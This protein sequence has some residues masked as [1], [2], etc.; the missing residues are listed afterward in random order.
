MKILK[1]V[2]AAVL[3]AVMLAA[4][5]GCSQEAG[6]TESTAAT[7]GNQNGETAVYTVHVETAGG[8][9]ME[10]LD[11]YVYTDSTLQDL[12]NV[13]RTGADG[14]VNLELPVS[15]TYAVTVAAPKGYQMEQSYSFSGNT[16]K[17]CL[18]SA[19]I[20][21]DSLS[22]AVLGVGDVMYDFTVT[23]PSGT[24]VRLSDVLAEKKM[25]ALNFWYTG[26][27][28][29]VTE[30]PFMEQ[31]YQTYKEDVEVIAVDP[32]GESNE[33]IA[34]FQAQQGLTFPMAECPSAW[35]ATF[36][37]TGYPTTVFIDRYGVICAIERGAIT[38]LRP[39]TCVFEHFTAEDYAQKLCANGIS[40][41]I[42]TVKPTEQMPSSDEINAVINSGNVQVTFRAEEDPDSAENTWP[43]VITEKNGEGCIKA[44]NQT[45]EDSYAIIYMDVTLQA[46]QALG[47]DYLASTERGSDIMY[48]IVDDEDIYAISGME[49]EEQW[50]TCYPWVAQEDGTFEVALCYLK[51]SD[52][53]VGDDTV[54]VKNLRVVDSSEIDTP[55]YIPFHAATS[56]DGFEY[57]YPEVFLGEDNYYHVGS[58]NGPLLL[59]EMTNYSQFSEE[60][61][62]WNLVYDDELKIN[63]EVMYDKMLQ[64]F[65]Y[66]SNSSL[67]GVCT[68]NAELG[69]L[70]QEVAKEVGFNTEDENEWLKFCKYYQAYGTDGTQLQD[71]IA[72][73][74][75]F[76]A[77]T[78]T[79]GSNVESNYFY[80][81]RPI[82]PRGLL[83]EF[84]PNR[85]GVYRITSRCDSEHGVEGWIFGAGHEELY[86]YEAAERVD[87]DGVNVNMLYYMEAGKSYYIDI[88]FWDMYEVGYIYYDIAYVA[89][90]Y[91][92]FR[93]A[94]PGYFTY[95]T[96]ATGEAMYH[97]IAGGVD[98]V[99]GDDG[100]YY[101]DMG[102]DADGN[103]I[104][105]S[106]LYADFTGT[107][108]IHKPIATVPSYNADG[109]AVKDK[110]GNPVMIEGMI[111]LGAF[112]FSRSEDDMY[113]LTIMENHNNDVEET[114][115][116][117]RELWGADYD[118]YAELYMLEDVYEGKYHGEG[119]DLTEEIS[120]YLDDM[121]TS[122]KQETIGCVVVTEELAQILQQIM[123]KYTFAGVD[124]SWTKLCYYYQHLGPNG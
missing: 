117:L 65:S 4:M 19:L 6:S 51:D 72:G 54:Y 3:A 25:V 62:L 56:Q 48:V 46:G 113:I 120:E 9:P 124:H 18:Q 80:Y 20:T 76:S 61:T 15:S 7:G 36:G 30:F 91:D 5:A 16:A 114:D 69:Q 35:S 122:G 73:L 45:V 89:S 108:V 23:T 38:S 55:T 28:W 97:T 92:L 95:D 107:T 84:V 74:A 103:Q 101:V 24:T 115:A 49:E 75:E 12:Q 94:S 59:A 100:I 57:S 85:S 1:R 79:L 29:C 102:K 44:S 78:A 33:A 37:I 111:D 90:Q 40:D 2:L 41:L 32:M 87:H 66:A 67:N 22:N 47:F 11:V 50:K 60:E 64:Y 63:G 88:A 21:D 93:L 14:N 86:T 119:E 112:D 96:D 26:C 81:D 43:F 8:M 70:L 121:I 10:N 109:T 104:Y 77:Y 71:P 42:T 123:D 39:F 34:A 52:T 105:G 82:I 68:V 99:L 106:K 83:A 118:T 13:G 53:T 116:Y 58:E 110:D 27:T 98:V 31:A 17:I